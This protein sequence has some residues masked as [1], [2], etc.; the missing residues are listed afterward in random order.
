M[1][2]KY[3]F[4]KSV[5]DFEN[6]LQRFP[7]KFKKFWK[8]IHSETPPKI[9]P[10]EIRPKQNDNGESRMANFPYIE[11]STVAKNECVMVQQHYTETHFFQN[12][13]WENAERLLLLAVFIYCALWLK[14]F[15]KNLVKTASEIATINF[16]GFLQKFL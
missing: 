10:E 16:Q 13:I 4:K 7:H 11:L 3:S 8:W 15:S 6:I 1:S 12:K 5:R 14:I 9:F 2:S